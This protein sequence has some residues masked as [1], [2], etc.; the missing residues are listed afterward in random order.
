MICNITASIQCIFYVGLRLLFFL[1]TCRIPSILCGTY[2]RRLQFFLVGC[3][4]DICH[5]PRYDHNLHYKIM[6]PKAE[7]PHHTLE[8][9]HKVSLDLS[10]IRH[11]PVFLCKTP[12]EFLSGLYAMTIA[13]V[14]VIFLGMK[15]LVKFYAG[16]SF[17]EI[18]QAIN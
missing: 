3:F 10:A 8:I 6:W 17:I 9:W 7:N 12:V 15:S 18:R 14:W 16:D 11:Q 4:W 5:F 13:Y 1:C 2:G